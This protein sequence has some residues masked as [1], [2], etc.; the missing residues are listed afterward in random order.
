MAVFGAGPLKRRRWHSEVRTGVLGD[1]ATGPGGASGG[2]APPTPG[3]GVPA[4]MGPSPHKTGVLGDAA[5]GPR[6]GPP[7]DQPHP[8]R[9]LGFQPPHWRQGVSAV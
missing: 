3:A 6:E 8:H 2:P 1:A 4:S 5:T 7:E 9:G